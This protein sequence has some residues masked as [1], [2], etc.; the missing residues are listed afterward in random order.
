VVKYLWRK[1]NPPL[2]VRAMAGANDRLFMAGP[3]DLVDETKIHGKFLEPDS[4]AALQKQQAALD[5][6]NGALLWAVSIR[7]GKKLA[8]YN[9]KGLPVF[10]GLI[11]ANGRLYLSLE[12]GELVCMK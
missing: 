4:E 7:D 5:G 6:K 11:A 10:D 2:L 12:T 3:P 9:L 1:L 8:Q